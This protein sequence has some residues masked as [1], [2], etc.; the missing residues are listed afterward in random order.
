[1]RLSARPAKPPLHKTLPL[2]P[3]PLEWGGAKAHR[4]FKIGPGRGWQPGCQPS[5]CPLTVWCLHSLGKGQLEHAVLHELRAT[6]I[7]A[8]VPADPPLA[9]EDRTNRPAQ[10]C[11]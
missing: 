2:V 3:L 10:I 4:G 6:K 9:P 7:G 5:S 8:G 11:R 1:M